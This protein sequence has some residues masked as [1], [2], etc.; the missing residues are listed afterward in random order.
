MNIAADSPAFRAVQRSREKPSFSHWHEVQEESGI[1]RDVY[2]PLFQRLDTL[3]RPRIRG[4]DER[5][6]ATMREMG[7][8]F[9]IS[10]NRAWG[11]RSGIATCCHRSS[12]PRNGTPSSA[13]S[14]SG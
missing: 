6:E 11:R 1:A 7:V 4:L 13:A 14:P 2:R 9:E 5:L 8:T 10:R 3:S 12:P